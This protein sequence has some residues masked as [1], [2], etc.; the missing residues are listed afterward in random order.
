MTD[1]L[2]W[3]CPMNNLRSQWLYASVRLLLIQD[4]G[5]LAEVAAWP[6][7]SVKDRIAL[8]MILKAEEA[9]LI[10]PDKT[11]LVRR[12]PLR[13]LPPGIQTWPCQLLQATRVPVMLLHRCQPAQRLQH[14][15]TCHAVATPCAKAHH[16]SSRHCHH[17]R[18]HACP[19]QEH[20][21]PLPG[22]IAAL[23]L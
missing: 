21:E 11:T 12:L 13:S 16:M 15:P 3:P 5:R 10:S 18:P 9:G 17:M 7:H 14:A 4:R 20:C 23:M 6:S 2:Q 1:C 19:C 8:N 22:S